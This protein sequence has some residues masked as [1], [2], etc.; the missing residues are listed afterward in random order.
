MKSLW[1]RLN[2]DLSSV[3]MY[4]SPLQAIVTAIMHLQLGFRISCLPYPLLEHYIERKIES[5]C[6]RETLLGRLTRRP[7]EPPCSPL[8]SVYS[9]LQNTSNERKSEG[10]VHP[11]QLHAL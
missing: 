9:S 2:H 1:P 6:H 10:S 5:Q 11:V 7:L 4:P 3:Y 8:S